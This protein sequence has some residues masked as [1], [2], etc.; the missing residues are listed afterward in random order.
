MYLLSQVLSGV[1]ISGPRSLPGGWYG[2]GRGGLPYTRYL[3]APVLTSSAGHRNGRYASCWNAFLC[4]WLGMQLKLSCSVK[5]FT[6]HKPIWSQPWYRSHSSSGLIRMSRRVYHVM[7][8]TGRLACPG[9]K[10][11]IAASFIVVTAGMRTKIC[12]QIIRSKG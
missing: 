5:T 2:G 10:H 3:P 4:V 6:W 9:Q 1:G 11:K 8:Y 7:T 12:D